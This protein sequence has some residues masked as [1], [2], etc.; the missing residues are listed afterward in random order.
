MEPNRT[1]FAVLKL[2]SEKTETIISNVLKMLSNRIFIDKSGNK[3]PLIDLEKAK[4]S[5]VL[6]PDG[7]YTLVANNRDTYAI[8]IIFQKISAISKQSVIS[9]FFKDYPTQKKI[10]IARDFNNKIA[11]HVSKHST[12]IF[13][14]SSLL[15]DI[16]SHRD[17]PIFELLSP[18]EAELFKAEYNATDYTT[19]KLLRSDAI[20][21]YYNLRR[22]DV[23]RIIRP[24]PTSGESIDYRIVY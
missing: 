1:L 11:E 3:N 15:Q 19:K 14:E 2:D 20:T 13:R 21:K 5:I 7:T 23:V 10:I 17:Q 12:Q 22:G 9:E 6:G 18:K 4:N 16:I 8:K 24:S